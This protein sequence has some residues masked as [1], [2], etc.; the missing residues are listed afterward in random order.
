[1]RFVNHMLPYFVLKRNEIYFLCQGYKSLG[2]ATYTHE[3]EKSC[4]SSQKVK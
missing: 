1:M 4:G 2:N 3:Q